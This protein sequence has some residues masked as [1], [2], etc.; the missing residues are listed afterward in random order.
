M[1]SAS[2]ETVDASPTKAFFVNMLT[3]DIKLEEAVL[4]LLDNCVDGIIRSGKKGGPK[5][6]DSYWAKIEFDKE[7]FSISD[8]CGG[9]PWD[10]REYA[11]RMGRPRENKPR[12]SR[13]VGVYGIGMKRAM[14]KIGNRCHVSTQNGNE[15][16]SVEIT[17]DW[18]KNEDVWEI[19]VDGPYQDSGSAGTTITVRDLNKGIAEM[20]GKNKAGKYFS[21]RLI[22]IIGAHY[23]YIIGKGLEV[24]INGVTVKPEMVRIAFDRECG[25]DGAIVPYVF[26]GEEDGVKVFMAVGLTGRTRSKNRTGRSG[27]TESLPPSDAGWTVVCNDRAVLSYDRT[28]LT[29]WGDGASRYHT[30]YSAI[31]G[32]VE[33]E[34]EDPAN[35]PTTTTK[36]GVDV[37]SPLYIRVKGQMIE[38]MKIFMRYTNQWKGKAAESD[39]HVERCDMLSLDELKDK[40]MPFKTAHA[41]DECVQYKPTLPSPSELNQR[42]ITFKRDIKKIKAVA[43]YFGEPDLRPSH[44]GAKCFD[45]FYARTLR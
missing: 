39:E 32:I 23:A 20:F 3:R 31:T 27:N 15:R 34:S 44:V 28:G 21:S 8:N 29:G 17:P 33:F 45:K 6:Y 37:S 7:R 2:G 24:T 19:D 12:I 5:P 30:Q 4:D 35:L 26:K 18:M 13:S 22:D 9:I 16:Y 25:R 10:D 42:T 43:E 40:R 14:F 38:G 1:N 41:L 36:T 11:F